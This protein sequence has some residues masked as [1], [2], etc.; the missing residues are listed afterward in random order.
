MN[1]DAS[2]MEEK[3]VSGNDIGSLWLDSKV[4]VSIFHTLIFG[5]VR[6]II[7]TVLRESRDPML[8]QHVSWF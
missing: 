8:Q 1:V 5:F 6:E 2:W 4:F 7:A 3:S